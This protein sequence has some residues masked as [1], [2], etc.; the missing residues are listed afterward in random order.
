MMGFRVQALAIIV[1]TGAVVHSGA[2]AEPWARHTIDGSSRGADGVRL[3]DVN[4]DGYLDIATGWEEGGVVRVYLNPG[5]DGV[6]DPWPAVTVGRVGAPED[7]VFVDLDGDGAMDV[8]SSCEGGVQTM[9]VHWAPK[10]REAYLDTQAWR[11]EPIPASEGR[12]RWMFC[13]PMDVDGQ[14]GIDLV[15]GSKD[16]N[17]LVGWFEAP[18]DARDLD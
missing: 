6:R 10:E 14:H 5:P 1:V 2:F 17:S 12:T 4:G 16:P 9:Y 3:A 18:A 15:A 7:A 13:V 11:T 8:V